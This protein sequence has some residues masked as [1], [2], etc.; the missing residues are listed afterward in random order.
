MWVDS[1]QTKVPVIIV[2]KEHVT[3]CNSDIDVFLIV[4][5]VWTP[6]GCLGNSVLTHSVE[7]LLVVSLPELNGPRI[8]G[9]EDGTS[10]EGSQWGVENGGEQS[11]EQQHG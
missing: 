6:P 10:Q 9:N 3:Q 7:A 4:L 11:L 1:K 2:M 5:E 8:G